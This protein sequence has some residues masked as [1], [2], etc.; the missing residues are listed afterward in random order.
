MKKNA[1]TYRNVLCGGLIY[2]A[3]GAFQI[4]TAGFASPSPPPGF[5]NTPSNEPQFRTDQWV[6]GSARSHADLSVGGRRVQIPVYFRVSSA[7]APQFAARY[8]FRHPLVA[9]AGAAAVLAPLAIEFANGQWNRAVDP[10]T[11]YP[12]SDGFLWFT[13]YGTTNFSVVPGLTPVQHCNMQFAASGETCRFVRFQD[14]SQVIHRIRTSDNMNMFGHLYTRSN[15]P[16]CPAGW[17]ITPAGCVQ[18]P[19]PV[20]RPLTEDEFVPLVAPQISP[21]QVPNIVPNTVPIPVE[22][23]VIN[24]EPRIVPIP[25]TPPVPRPLIAPLADPV[26]IPN[27][28]PQQ[29]RQPLVQINPSPTVDNPWRVSLNPIERITTSPDGI[30]QP[31]SNVDP[32]TPVRPAPDSDF[33]LRNPGVLACAPIPV[34]DIPTD[35]IPTA[36]Q[37]ITYQPEHFLGG[38]SCPRPVTINL[39][40][41][42]ITAF[43]TPVYCQFISSY[44]RPVFLAIA[45]F[46]SMMIVAGAFRSV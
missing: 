17:F 31:V 4:A 24:P 45:A 10:S 34:L 19:P 3:L 43:D 38:G 46:S 15:N 7:N 33:C 28:E 5:S 40:G 42:S 37:L 11:I 1:F 21:S 26:M 20:T 12:I 39:A 14:T 6:N 27:T 22:T 23:P 35:Q 13:R 41:R 36:T 25:Y 9:A 32:A 18:T 16:N 30:T 44:F 8:L 29:W 2:A